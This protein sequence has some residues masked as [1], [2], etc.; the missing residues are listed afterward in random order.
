MNDKDNPPDKDVKLPRMDLLKSCLVF[1]L[2]A[3]FCSM[4]HILLLDYFSFGTLIKTT[5]IFN[6]LSINLVHTDLNNSKPIKIKVE[7]LR[8]G[9]QEPLSREQKLAYVDQ[10]RNTPQLPCN[11]ISIKVP[12]TGSSTT[13]P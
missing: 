8:S 4:F 7:K 5:F 10:S 11:L 3:G 2:I 6:S 13:G 9:S 1:M 12:K